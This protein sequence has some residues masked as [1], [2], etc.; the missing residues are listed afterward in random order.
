MHRASETAARALWERGRARWPGVQLPF[1]T[2]AAHLFARN[3]GELAAEGAGLHAE[4]LYLAC[5]CLTST[6]GAAETFKAE[7]EEVIFRFVRSVE[8]RPD[9]AREQVHELF[10]RVLVGDQDAGPR[11]AEYSGRGPLRAWLRMSAV[12]RTL[13]SRRDQRRRTELEIQLA[14]ETDEHTS[15]PELAII[16]QRYRPALIAALRDS[17]AALP[18]AERTLLKL[19][20]QEQLDLG[21]IA[22]MNGWSK[23]TASRRVSAAR[24]AVH[25]G[26]TALLIERLRVEPT[27]LESLLG[28]LR[29]QLVVSL[30]GLFGERLP[31]QE[32]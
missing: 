32:P 1:E 21:A 29:S 12:R 10:V 13:N 25:E 4:D 27:E 3:P 17:I 30:T 7:Y 14:D 9:A 24:R 31:S 19:H 28:M 11:L 26:T 6:S 23:P 22:A 2:Y 20:Y 8:R 18:P 16:R 5:A 15:S